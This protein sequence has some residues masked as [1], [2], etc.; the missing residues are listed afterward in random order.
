MTVTYIEY[1]AFSGKPDKHA[2]YIRKKTK[3]ENGKRVEY[4]APGHF[5]ITT[6]ESKFKAIGKDFKNSPYRAADLIPIFKEKH[7]RTFFG[8][9][10]YFFSTEAFRY[11]KSKIE[12]FNLNNSPKIDVNNIKLVLDVISQVYGVIYLKQLK[13]YLEDPIFMSFVKVNCSSSSDIRVVKNHI[14]YF[15]SKHTE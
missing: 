14:E 12:G 13:S 11:C 3:K 6:G 4:F 10:Y 1:S 9:T 8:A 2:F 5:A 15:K 7:A